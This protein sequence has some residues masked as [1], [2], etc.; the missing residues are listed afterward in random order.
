MKKYI[1]FRSVNNYFQNDK[2]IYIF[3]IDDYVVSR[4]VLLMLS[5][6]ELNKYIWTIAYGLMCDQK[7]LL[8]DWN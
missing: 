3:S 5:N 2:L 6:A 7:V 1:L 8:S 4:S